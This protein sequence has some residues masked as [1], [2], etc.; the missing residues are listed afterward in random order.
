MIA[1]LLALGCKEAQEGPLS[2][3]ILETPL[4]ECAKTV[5]VKGFVPGALIDIYANG[6]TRIGGGTSDAPWGQSFAVT[7]ELIAGQEITVRQTFDGI[8]S[9][10]S[11][12][13]KVVN[14]RKFYGGALPKPVLNTPIFD[15]GGAIGVNNLAPGGIL[16]VY[17]DGTEIGRVDG[18][19]AGQW[20]HVSPAFEKG[21]TITADVEICAIKSPLSDPFVVLE[22]P[23]S[24]PQLEVGDIYE[25][26]KYVNVY[27]ITNGARVKT[28]AN[29]TVFDDQAYSG[30][31]QVVRVPP[32]I[33]V[34]DK[35]TA[36]QELCGTF[37]EPSD[38]STVQPCS[39]LPPPVL[40]Q[41]C[42]G[43]TR[44]K[45]VS[46]A[47]GARVQVYRNGVII[48]D[49][50]GDEIT[51]LSAVAGGETFTA[52]QSLGTCISPMSLPMIVSC[53]KPVVNGVT[54]PYAGRA[55]SIAVD[56]N[57]DNR[58]L[59]A[60]ESG[61]MFR[62]T[63]RGLNWTHVS[64][65]QHFLFSDVVFLPFKDGTV[66]ATTNED[67]RVKSGGGIWRSVN[68]GS[69]WKQVKLTTPTPACVNNIAGYSVCVQKGTKRVWAGTSCGLAYSDDAGATWTFQ[70]TVTGYSPQ[71]V[72]AVETPSDTKIAIVIDAG[73]VVST[74]QGGT[75][76]AV[77][78]PVGKPD[79]ADGAHN[80]L[81]TGFGEEEHLFYTLY[82]GV[83]AD[84]VLRRSVF[85]ST[86]FGN[87]WDDI[88][89]DK[90]PD[91]SN[92]PLY[93]RTAG[94]P[95]GDAN[96]YMVYFGDGS[97]GFKRRMIKS[98]NGGT[99]GDWSDMTMDHADPSDV[100]FANDGK[101]PLILTTD[102]GIHNTSNGGKDWKL[103]GGGPAGYNALQITEVRAQLQREGRSTDLYFGTQDNDIWASSDMGAT[104][105]GQ[106]RWEG[107]FLNISRNFVPDDQNR[108]NGVAC[109]ACGNYISKRLLA[110]KGD[111]PNPARSNGSPK[112]IN[113]A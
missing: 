37:S 8:V 64:A 26:G 113:P 41:L 31:G 82:H 72:F 25:N 10:A 6:T 85:F 33:V 108:S 101:T 67:T 77:P 40:G 15:C 96:R 3:P 91:G 68:H 60:S 92:R 93:V 4:L 69:T 36:V 58:I 1:V 12:P 20:L 49:G 61:G 22:K 23:S 48:A 70:A 32:T 83:T 84:N 57:D 38:P 46:S 45:V 29:G 52:K 19:G 66:I 9:P 42:P 107:F 39:A 51:L 53:S 44:V 62:S 73:L 30:G 2:P 11:L 94:S 21:K 95:K 56:P 34:G 97:S 47:L 7:P 105:P 98:G 89:S 5:T 18:C 106:V 13:I 90:L 112:L 102:G 55:V 100:A 27:N 111:F 35:L 103:V 80:Q 109:G 65:S 78:F 104:W 75:F 14:P 71:P 76:T 87:T 63:N 81:A 79:W 59:V 43:D 88:L 110:G 86:D 28:S 17:S 54:I 74:D 16:R 24:L 50:G 99:D